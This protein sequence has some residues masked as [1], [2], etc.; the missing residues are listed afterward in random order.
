MTEQSSPQKCRK[1]LARLFFVR[2]AAHSS[3]EQNQ[4]RLLRPAHARDFDARRRPGERTGL[5]FRKR[6]KNRKRV[7]AAPA[8]EP[9]EIL[10][11]RP[12]GMATMS[13]AMPGERIAG[14]R[15]LPCCEAIS[16]RSPCSIFRLLR[17]LGVDFDPARP[18]RRGEHVRHLLQP[19]QVRERAIAERLRGMYGRK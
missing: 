6:R 2:K 9:A 15:T 13:G 14:A 11:P 17:G 18:H 8:G 19:G 4:L 16:T 3:S 5:A 7:R 10:V 12:T 1:K